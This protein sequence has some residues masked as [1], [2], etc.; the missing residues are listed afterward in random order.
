[1]TCVLQCVNKIWVRVDGSELLDGGDLRMAAQ[2]LE[3][4]E[5]DEDKKK[6]FVD[7]DE[8][9]S[10]EG[11][12]SD[13]SD[14]DPNDDHDDVSVHDDAA[15]DEVKIDRGYNHEVLHEALKSACKKIY[16]KKISTN[17]PIQ[18]A[19]NQ[20]T[21]H[22]LMFGRLNKKYFTNTFSSAAQKLARKP[23]SKES[24]SWG[25]C[26]GL[27]C[28]SRLVHCG[29]QTK[30]LTM[31]RAFGHPKMKRMYMCEVWGLYRVQID[32]DAITL[33]QVQLLVCANN[34]YPIT[35]MCLLTF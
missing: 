5:S 27:D 19:I 7:D 3:A 10:T 18:Y 9:D 14:Y 20:K 15:S 8:D 25:H 1:M 21:G 28:G 30:Q 13:D 22:F 26:V 17:K 12:S 24:G 11:D 32:D 4:A 6:R 23:I 29:M 16:W 2:R 33:R 35:I 34:V 31:E